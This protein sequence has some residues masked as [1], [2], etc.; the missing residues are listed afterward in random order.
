MPR[1]PRDRVP[2]LPSPKSSSCPCSSRAI[3]SL[4]KSF[5]LLLLLLILARESRPIIIVAQLAGNCPIIRHARASV[6]LSVNFHVEKITALSTD[7]ENFGLCLFRPREHLPCSRSISPSLRSKPSPISHPL[8]FIIV[9]TVL[10]FPPR[11]ATDRNTATMQ[12]RIFGPGRFSARDTSIM[13]V[14]SELFP[15]RVA[16]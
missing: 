4:D 8:F 5:V 12:H 3:T 15:P 13:R 1:V 11:T 9:P 14:T 6:R 7:R 10:R 2:P 16:I